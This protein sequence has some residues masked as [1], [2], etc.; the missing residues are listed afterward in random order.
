MKKYLI[1][2]TE[3]PYDAMVNDPSWLIPIDDMKEG[4]NKDDA[5]IEK[6]QT[7]QVHG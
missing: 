6:L 4:E 5:K 3:L 1:D 7:D 2:R